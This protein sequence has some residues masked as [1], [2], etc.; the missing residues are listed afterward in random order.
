MFFLLFFQKDGRLK[1]SQKICWEPTFPF[2]SLSILDFYYYCNFRDEYFLYTL[3]KF[4]QSFEVS[5]FVKSSFLLFT[6]I[7]WF[8]SRG[9]RSFICFS[10]CVFSILVFHYYTPHLF[11]VWIFKFRTPKSFFQLFY[12]VIDYL[13]I[14]PPISCLHVLFFYCFPFMM[15]CL[16][17]KNLFFTETSGDRFI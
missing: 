11:V 16:L 17:K 10:Y 4:R 13:I 2:T 6:I 5:R 7:L 9:I 1:N 8:K 3:C 14:I 15:I 12:S